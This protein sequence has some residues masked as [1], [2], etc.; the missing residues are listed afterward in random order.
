MEGIALHELKD[1]SWILQEI[2]YRHII[3]QNAHIER[4]SNRLA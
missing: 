3:T 1:I 2:L 4:C